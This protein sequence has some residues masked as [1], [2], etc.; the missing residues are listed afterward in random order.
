MVMNKTFLAA[1]FMAIAGAALSA[2]EAQPCPP[3]HIFRV[4]QGVCQPKAAGAWQGGG[5]RSPLRP[6]AAAPAVGDLVVFGPNGPLLLKPNAPRPAATRP[7]FRP[8]P[9]KRIASRPA[10]IKGSAPRP[11]AAVGPART[12]LASADAP[13]DE[14]EL[15]KRVSAFLGRLNI[16]DQKVEE[17]VLAELRKAEAAP[18]PVTKERP[19][20][21]ASDAAADAPPATRIARGSEPTEPTA[22]TAAPA[23]VKPPAAPEAPV[24]LGAAA[25]K[26]QKQARA[27]TGTQPPPPRPAAPTTSGLPDWGD[28]KKLVETLRA[29]WKSG[30]VTRSFHRGDEVPPE[31]PLQPL[32]PP[33]A[34]R[35][36]G[37]NMSYVMADGD[38]V[39]VLP[40]MRVV[41]DVYHSATASTADR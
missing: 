4:S 20:R 16:A 14:T 33:L 40:G 3:G 12:T 23:S 21:Q 27:D 34:S 32:P 7:A 15:R 13:R 37:V 17:A 36:A 11:P 26:D 18:E 2:A 31:V 30:Q 9:A 41:V 22:A 38:A 10:A 24:P 8:R 1:G 6:S 19:S 5:G 35:A 28:E 25:D 29:N 39:L